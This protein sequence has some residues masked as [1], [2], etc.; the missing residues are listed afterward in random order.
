M[1][2]IVESKA[3][4]RQSVYQPI[5]SVKSAV[6]GQPVFPGTEEGPDMLLAMAMGQ[7]NAADDR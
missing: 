2:K 1:H 7:S 4:Q 6:G 3:V 5:D